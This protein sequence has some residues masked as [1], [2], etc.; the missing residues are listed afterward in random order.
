MAVLEFAR[1]RHSS[2]SDRLMTLFVW[3]CA[4]LVAAAFLA[5]L[6]DLLWHGGSRLSWQFLVT[7]PEN[8]GRAGGIAPIL[9]STLLILAVA[10][11]AAVPLGLAT[12]VWLSDFT[13]AGGRLARWVNLCLD[14]LAGVPS[15]VFGLFGNAFFSVTLGLGFSILSGGLTLAC[16]VL[17]IF[18]RSAESGLSAV[19]DDW[20][21]GAAALGLSRAAALRHILLPA[22]A[23]ALTVGLMLGSGRALAETAALVFTSGYVDRMPESLLDSGRALAVHI[24][25]LS[26]N[27]TGGD[28]AAYASALV[29]IVL[30]VSINSLAMALSDRFLARRITFS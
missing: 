2:R 17:P 25:D 23:P 5:L 16:M 12:A 29:L 9:V 4:T 1:K 6:A 10:L 22:A 27:V 30:L 13:R 8:A 11:A 15:I 28:G 3:G 24:Y 18:I 20:R 21:R 14:V 26:M 19:P 7:E